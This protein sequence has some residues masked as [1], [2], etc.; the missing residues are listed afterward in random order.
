MYGAINDQG[1]TYGYVEISGQIREVVGFY[2]ASGVGG[3]GDQGFVL[4]SDGNYITIEAPVAADTQLFG[5]N[6][7]GDVIGWMHG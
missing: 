1:E 4:T 2:E 7:Q 6:D 3:G 5:I